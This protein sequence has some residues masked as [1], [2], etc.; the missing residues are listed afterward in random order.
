MI[1]PFIFYYAN[2][3]KKVYDKYNFHIILEKKRRGLRGTLGSPFRF[4]F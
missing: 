1:P 3:N 4:S 2:Y